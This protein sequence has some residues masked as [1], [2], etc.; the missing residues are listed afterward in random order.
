MKVNAINKT[1]VLLINDFIVSL[2]KMIYGI[3]FSDKDIEKG[4]EEAMVS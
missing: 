3:Y 2:K 4:N 1:I